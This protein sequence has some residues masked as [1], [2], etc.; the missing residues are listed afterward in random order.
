MEGRSLS[1]KKGQAKE[2]LYGIKVSRTIKIMHLLFV[3]DVLIMT[4]DLIE[5]WEEIN[6]I[7][8]VFCSAMGLMINVKKS[9]SLHFGVQ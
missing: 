9:T 7:L 3:D 8:D 2:K 1:L 6:K 4:K 5:E